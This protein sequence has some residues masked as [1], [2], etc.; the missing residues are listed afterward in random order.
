MS[1]YELGLAANAHGKSVMTAS[2]LTAALSR[3]KTL[4]PLEDFTEPYDSFRLGGA[5]AQRANMDGIFQMMSS[6][7]KAQQAVDKGAE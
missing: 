2:W 1:A 7:A 3:P 4:K 5:A 6:M